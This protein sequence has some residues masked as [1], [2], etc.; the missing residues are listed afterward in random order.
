M[1]FSQLLNLE[2]WTGT[3]FL[4]VVAGSNV[5]DTITPTCVGSEAAMPFCCSI[6]KMSSTE[7]GTKFQAYAHLKDDA[8][9]EGDFVT[10]RGALVRLLKDDLRKFH[11]GQKPRHLDSRCLRGM[12]SEGCNVEYKRPT[13][14]LRSTKNRQRRDKGQARFAR[15]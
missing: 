2:S 13:K 6:L 5:N 14:V 4:L 1:F 7:Y 8:L 12:W 3:R 10:K 15:W 9:I 11:R